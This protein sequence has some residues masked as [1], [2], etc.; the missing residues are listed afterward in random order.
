MSCALLFC[1]I[2][3]KWSQ[4]VSVSW[5]LMGWVILNCYSRMYLGVHYPLDIVGGLIVG[6]LTAVAVYEMLDRLGL[7]TTKTDPSC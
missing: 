3:N 5:C 7:L 2:W 4:T 6:S 1:L